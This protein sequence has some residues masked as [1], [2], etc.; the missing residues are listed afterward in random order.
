MSGSIDR[1]CIARD[2]QIDWLTD[3][4]YIFVLPDVTES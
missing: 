2:C 3:Q 1:I 4:M